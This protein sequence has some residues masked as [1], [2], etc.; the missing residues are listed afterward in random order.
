MHGTIFLNLGSLAWCEWK[1]GIV[2][3]R[4]WCAA[5]RSPSVSVSIRRT[6]SLMV[7]F[8]SGYLCFPLL[9]GALTGV[10]R[11]LFGGCDEPASALLLDGGWEDSG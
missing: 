3:V 11:N 4:E 10:S 9:I 7:L 5:H 6:S 8:S 1:E 2:I